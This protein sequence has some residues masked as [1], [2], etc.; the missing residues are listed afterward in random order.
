MWPTAEICKLL[1]CFARA[2]CLW[3]HEACG[4]GLRTNSK[5]FP[6]N[7]RSGPGRPVAEICRELQDLLAT[8]SGPACP[9]KGIGAG[10]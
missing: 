6:A 4:P 2:S 7:L 1:V 8:R 3:G 9:V 5:Q 10:P